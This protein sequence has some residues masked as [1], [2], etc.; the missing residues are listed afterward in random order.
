MAKDYY[1]LRKTI[2]Y[3]KKKGYEVEKLE[4]TYRVY[5]KKRN[6][7]IFVKQ[8]IFNSD[9]LAMNENEVIFIQLKTNKSDISKG[10]KAYKRM[11][12]PVGKWNIKFWVVSWEKRKKNPI[13]VDVDEVLEGERED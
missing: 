8:D 7:V 12:R 2:D 4:K 11:K 1:Y 6:N 10:I 13:I 3:F 9:L 5:D